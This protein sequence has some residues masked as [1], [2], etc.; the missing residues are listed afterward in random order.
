MSKPIPV[1]RVRTNVRARLSS[2]PISGG[3]ND[4]TV[5]P[6]IPRMQM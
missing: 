4:G 1:G 6:L 5:G 2:T 3:W